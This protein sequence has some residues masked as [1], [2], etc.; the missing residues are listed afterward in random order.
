MTTQLT[1]TI[2]GIIG[3]IIGLLIDRNARRERDEKIRQLEGELVIKQN[4]V[5]SQNA[6]IGRLRK[7]LDKRNGRETE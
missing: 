6:T 4:V 7:K 1:I 3:L 5:E 2:A